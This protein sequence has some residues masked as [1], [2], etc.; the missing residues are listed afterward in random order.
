MASTGQ[1]L[2]H[3]LRGLARRPSF[4]LV[5]VLSLAAGIGVNTAVFTWIDYLVL[6]PVPGVDLLSL[7]HI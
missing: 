7:I 2:R 1:D 3:A 6:A 5:A 4:A